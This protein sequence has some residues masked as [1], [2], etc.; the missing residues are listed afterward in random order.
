MA[1]I[2]QLFIIDDDNETIWKITHIQGGYEISKLKSGTNYDEDE[3][4]TEYEGIIYN[5][6]R[7]A[8]HQLGIDWDNLIN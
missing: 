6:P 7:S 3:A 4:F 5:D 8:L 2:T 1:I